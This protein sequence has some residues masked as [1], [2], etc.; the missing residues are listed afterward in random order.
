MANNATFCCWH[1]ERQRIYRVSTD[2]GIKKNSVSS[3]KT[4]KVVARKKYH[5]DY[6]RTEGAVFR[7]KY[8]KQGKNLLLGRYAKDKNRHVPDKLLIKS[9]PTPKKR[10]K[11][12]ASETKCT[13]CGRLGHKKAECIE[14]LKQPTKKKRKT[15]DGM[16]VKEME[17]CF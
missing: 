16:S 4:A 10:K 5:S 3:I 17:D 14:V 9:K 11:K 12:T 8:S 2:I 15:A 7:R 6:K 13:N 1:F